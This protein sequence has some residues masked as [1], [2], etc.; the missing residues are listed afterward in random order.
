MGC[1]QQTSIET[2]RSHYSNNNNLILSENHE[3][4]N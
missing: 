4:L 2:D 3:L 1:S